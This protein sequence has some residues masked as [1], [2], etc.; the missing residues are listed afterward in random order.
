MFQ[1]VKFLSYFVQSYDPEMYLAATASRRLR[2]V[3]CG[4]TSV[5]VRPTQTVMFTQ[6]RQHITI[7][8]H[9]KTFDSTTIQQETYR[10]LTRGEIEK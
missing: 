5:D 8:K 7:I 4:G 9:L 6:L 10:M 1:Y 2:F 3:V